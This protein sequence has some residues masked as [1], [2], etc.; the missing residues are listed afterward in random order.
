M[1]DLPN[2]GTKRELK[3][4]TDVETSNSAAKNDFIAL[5]TEVGELDFNKL[6]NV[7]ADLNNLK[8][9]VD[10]LD[11]GKLK[12]VPIDFKKT[13]DVVDKQTKYESK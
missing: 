3:D 13:V 9:K 2:Y 4:A 7:R 5:K 1:L 8:T 11:V 6:V 12:T 10:K